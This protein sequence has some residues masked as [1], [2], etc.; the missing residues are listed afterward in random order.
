MNLIEE[1]NL[2]KNSSIIDIGCGE[3]RLIDSLIDKGFEDITALDISETSLKKLKSRI[4]IKRPNSVNYIVSDITNFTPHK[5]Y[6]L[7]H[8]RA[9][10]HFLTN[11]DDI[12]KYLQIAGEAIERDGYL[13][14]GTFSKSG[15]DKCSGLEISK[16]SENDLSILFKNSFNKVKCFEVVHTT[17][18]DSTQDFVYCLFK[19]KI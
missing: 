16:Y 13:I 2:S 4:E 17:P 12:E 7:W 14:I 1:L 15:P 5:K 3:S 6:K 18:W 19:K 8:D 9:A 11:Q 10:F